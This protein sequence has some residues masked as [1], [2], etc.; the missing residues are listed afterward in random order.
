MQEATRRDRQASRTDCSNVPE[1]IAGDICHIEW[2]YHERLDRT[3]GV[4]SHWIKKEK[5]SAK[6]RGHLERALDQ[7]RSMP[8][9]KW[10]KPNP[11]SNIG[12][13]TYVI[14]FRDV[15]NVQLRIFGHFHDPHDAFVMTFQGHE[16]DDT[17]YPKN[18]AELAKNYKTSCG[19]E[20]S[21]HTRAYLHY[22]EIC[23]P[24]QPAK[25]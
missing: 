25:G 9:S 7:L 10:S 20:F 17:Y 14:R 3:D 16:S 24:Q 19:K 21:K 6:A 15:G 12:N 2:N 8:K 22:C 5:I 11:A 13:H 23:E 18:Y 1:P 4:I